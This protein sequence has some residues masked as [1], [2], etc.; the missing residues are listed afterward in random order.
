LTRWWEQCSLRRMANILSDATKQQVIALG[1][2]GW[3]L[4]RIEVATGVRRETA[5][6]YLKAAGLAVRPPGRWGHPLAK[7]ATG[8][9]TDP[10]LPAAGAEPSPPAW[11]PRPQRAPAAS[12]CVPYRELIESAVARG[13][14]AMAIWR[15]LVDDHGFPARYAS[16]RRFVAMLRGQRSP[17]AHPVTGKHRRTRL[18]V[19]TLGYSRKSV[20]LLTFTSSAPTKTC[21]CRIS[22]VAGSTTGI[23]CPA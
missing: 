9:S 10:G 11:E 17:E 5:S 3:T 12:A 2:L 15:D 22:P 6:A 14:N 20:R 7:P 23:V 8:V 4:R 18:F 1:R 13:R 19:L 16:V 21:A